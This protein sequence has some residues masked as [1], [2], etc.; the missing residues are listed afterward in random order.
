MSIDQWTFKLVVRMSEKPRSRKISSSADPKKSRLAVAPVENLKEK[1]VSDVF[2]KITRF[3][4][5][6]YR[7]LSYQVK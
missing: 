7:D 1:Q 4:Q 3:Q 5:L 6:T 2:L